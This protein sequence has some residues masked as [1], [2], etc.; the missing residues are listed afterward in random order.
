M[1]RW[2]H[3]SLPRP[4]G[5]IAKPSIDHLMKMISKVLVDSSTLAGWNSGSLDNICP[6]LGDLT[7]MKTTAIT[8]RSYKT[9]RPPPAKSIHVAA[10]LTSRSR[11][12]Y[13]G[14][15]GRIFICK[16]WVNRLHRNC[17]RSYRVQ[18]LEIRASLPIVVAGNAGSKVK[19]HIALITSVNI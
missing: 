15:N 13:H 2:T 8:G 5:Q 6:L 19:I 16:L 9:G 1:D 12:S 10:A 11:S 18:E 3:K 7:R 4:Q 14:L 17:Y